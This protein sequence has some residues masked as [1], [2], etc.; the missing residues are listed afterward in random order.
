[1]NFKSLFSKCFGK[2]RSVP[3]VKEVVEEV[4][5]DNFIYAGLT[6]L[7]ALYV[8]IENT[9]IVQKDGQQF[10]AVYAKEK[11]T[12]T[13]FSKLLRKDANLKNVVGSFTLY[14]FDNTCSNYCVAAS[15]LI[16]KDENICLDYGSSLKMK[17]LTAK[18]TAMLNAYTLCLKALE[19][20]QNEQDAGTK[21]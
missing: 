15:Y 2:L 3:E 11:F 14:L 19:L 18:D 17:E 13:V 12:D 9:S 8:D 7:G 5:P 16:D 21:I 6:E 20:K 10:L 4:K 1:M